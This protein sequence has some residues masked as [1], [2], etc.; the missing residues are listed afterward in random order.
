MKKVASELFKQSQ[1]KLLRANERELANLS[2]QRDLFTVN[3]K[4]DANINDHKLIHSQHNLTIKHKL[5]D[6]KV[7]SVRLSS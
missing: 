4:K 3:F 1:I 5:S 7:D 2:R 6:S